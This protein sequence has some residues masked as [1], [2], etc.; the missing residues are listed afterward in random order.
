MNPADIMNLA[1]T[2]LNAILQL[3]SS[4]KAQHGLTDDE[5]LAQAKA[6]TAGNDDAYN[7]IVA[8]LQPPAA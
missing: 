2:G 3:V 6:I 5:I 8:A 7:A 1:L 4:I